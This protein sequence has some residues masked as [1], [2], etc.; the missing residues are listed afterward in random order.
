MEAIFETE[1]YK[2]HYRME[3]GK[4][5]QVVLT[6][7]D[8]RCSLLEIPGQIEGK[9]VTALAKKACFGS[10]AAKIILPDTLKEIG[11][12]AFAGCKRLTELWIPL[13]VEHFGRDIL[14]KSGQLEKLIIYEGTEPC[15]DSTAVLLALSVTV[16]QQGILLTSRDWGT[17]AWYEGWDRAC[18]DF[19][20]SPDEDGFSPILAG[21]EEDYIT[22]ENDVE[23]HC[24][25]RRLQ[26]VQLCYLRLRYADFLA[27]NAEKRY[28]DYLKQHNY[29]QK[30]AEAWDFLRNCQK[31][32]DRYYRL[33]AEA[34]CITEENVDSLIQA[35]DER[36]TELRAFLLRYQN[37]SLE[38]VDFFE[39]LLREI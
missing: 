36:D 25:R 18:M 26:K 19:L 12:W 4:A 11:D 30:Q 16:M 39:Q 2:I 5:D 7:V 33:F 17:K 6:E 10:R 31:D 3:S 13:E 27:E 35:L 37:E 21:G 23:Y 22:N 14:H 24:H 15:S 38:P 28:R 8:T 34:G 20:E 9:T 32:A 1:Q 29:G